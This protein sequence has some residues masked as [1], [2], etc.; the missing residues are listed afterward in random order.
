MTVR[1]RTQSPA[2]AALEAFF[3]DLRHCLAGEESPL[4]VGLPNFL[5]ALRDCSFGGQEQSSKPVLLGPGELAA[6]PR[7]L[8][9]LEQPIKVAEG[10]GLFGNPWTAAALHRNEVRN[11]RVLAWFLNPKGG[12]G[13]GDALLIAL[14]DQI[15]R[16]M[17]GGFPDRP[18]PSCAVSV[19]EYPDGLNRSR[20][21]IQIDDPAFFVI[22]EVK[23]DASEQ[24]GQLE[25]YCQIADE[26]TLGMRKWAV[27]FLT[28]DRNPPIQQG[29]R[30]ALIV[31]IAW[32]TIAASLRRAAHS[33]SSGRCAPL[34]VPRFLA[35]SFA[36][37]I[38]HFKGRP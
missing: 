17:P 34:G 32:A 29:D 22:I 38:S 31:P 6:L 9:M 1:S 8:E 13:C 35:N 7:L 11:A 27:V 24:P 26:R 12:H 37:H 20:V 28:K 16:H 2:A 36:T 3:A 15:G 4:T 23:I 25:R 14:L 19:E 30:S 5:D 21:D 33:R 18:G 10:A